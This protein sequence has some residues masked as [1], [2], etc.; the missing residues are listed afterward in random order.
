MA[1][2]SCPECNRSG[3]S[4]TTNACPGCG[5]NI[6]KHRQKPSLS[7]I[8]KDICERTERKFRERE[9]EKNQ[10]EIKEREKKAHDAH[11]D[12]IIS[13]IKMAE[14]NRREEQRKYIKPDI[15]D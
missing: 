6:Y 7:E 5:F 14:K 12:A 11:V 9:W 13:G 3:V 8:W 15:S 4:S 10:K 2:I 1:L